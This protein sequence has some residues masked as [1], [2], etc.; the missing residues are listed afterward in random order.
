MRAMPKPPA[1]QPTSSRRGATS[2]HFAIV[3]A[4]MGGIT[5]PRTQEPPGHQVTGV[6]K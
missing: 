4:G 1:P 2:R 3:G 5:N 6:E